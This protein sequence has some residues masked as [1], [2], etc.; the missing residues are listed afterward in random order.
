MKIGCAFGF[1][2][3]CGVFA[4]IAQLIG[5]IIPKVLVLDIELHTNN[6]ITLD[7]FVETVH[8]EV[9][10]EDSSDEE[11]ILEIESLVREDDE[12]MHKIER[13]ILE[14]RNKERNVT[15]AETKQKR[16]I[17]RKLD[18]K[19]GNATSV[20]SGGLLNEKNKDDVTNLRNDP[21]GDNAMS[22]DSGAVRV[23]K[24]DCTYSSEETSS[25]SEE[26]EEEA[27]KE[28][29]VKVKAED[30]ENGDK[31]KE[32][33]AENAEVDG[34]DSDDDDDYSSS[35]NESSESSEDEKEEE[36]NGGENEGTESHSIYS[37][38]SIGLWNSY[39]CK[40]DGSNLT[41]CTSMSFSD[42]LHILKKDAR[43][44]IEA[45]TYK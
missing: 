45:R 20:K 15:K 16:T 7:K 19:I 3:V 36:D 14:E 42:V 29:E 34:D 41:E 31:E 24:I 21:D 5:I 18:R 35:C 43:G 33:V 40:L 28:L 9:I 39:I 38:I 27:A 32:E 11:E 8:M 17:K 22:E 2:G 4:I 12:Y 23:I 30:K 37:S 13:L 25:S 44:F 10:E 26:E 6:N 1:I